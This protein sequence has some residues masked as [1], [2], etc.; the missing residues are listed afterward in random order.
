MRAPVTAVWPT[1]APAYRR[2]RASRLL[3]GDRSG[4]AWTKARTQPRA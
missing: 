2:L 3:S 4:C 1:V